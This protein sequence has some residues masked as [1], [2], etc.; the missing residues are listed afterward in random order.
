MSFIGSDSDFFPW[1]TMVIVSAC[2]GKFGGNTN[3][4]D[5]FKG[6]NNLNY[7]VFF[8]SILHIFYSILRKFLPIYAFKICILIKNWLLFALLFFQWKQAN[9][10]HYMIG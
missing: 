5:V 7:F 6:S 8:A 1:N 3:A 9:S 4:S 2:V 10:L